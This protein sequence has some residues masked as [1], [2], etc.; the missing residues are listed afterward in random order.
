MVVVVGLV[1]GGVRVSGGGGGRG[2][3][4]G[5]GWWEVVRGGGDVRALAVEKVPLTRSPQPGWG[6]GAPQLW[7]QCISEEA[8]W[9]RQ[10]AAQWWPRNVDAR[11]A[12]CTVS[13]CTPKSA[14]E[15]QLH[16][17]LT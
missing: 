14:H 13:F 1:G 4:E 12:V 5:G 11:E 15:A 9:R 7:H 10:A 16:G 2:S 17:I 6:V 8:A 3:S